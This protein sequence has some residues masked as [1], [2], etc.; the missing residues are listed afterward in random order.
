MVFDAKTLLAAHILISLVCLVV[1]WSTCRVGWRVGTRGPG[2]WFAG[3]GLITAGLGGLGLRGLLPDLVTVGLT[4]TC[5]YAGIG[6]HLLGVQA[7][8]QRPLWLKTTIGLTVLASLGHLALYWA[9]PA[10]GPRVILFALTY[11][12]ANAACAINLYFRSPAPVRPIA[13]QASILYALAALLYLYRLVTGLTLPDIGWMTGGPHEQ[14][15]LMGSMVVFAGMVYT[16]LQLMNNL[17]LADREQALETKALLHQEMHHRTKNNLALAEAL[18]Y[19]EAEQ[20]SD[21]VVKESLASLQAR[22][23]SIAVLH[24]HLARIDQGSAL[25]SLDRYLETMLAAIQPLSPGVDWS[26]EF[27]PVQVPLAMAL[28]VG[29]MV[30]ELVTNSLKYA[31]AGTDR[32]QIQVSLAAVPGNRA[33]VTVSDNGPGA[34]PGQD[35]S[36]GLGTMIITSLAEQIQASL[37]Y[38][39]TPGLTAELE[40]PLDKLPQYVEARNR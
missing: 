39:S 20:F 37:S 6:C 22:L 30:N 15:Y 31:R 34:H 7:F 35:D 16:E 2:L 13:R 38:R 3:F 4:N 28:P 23:H 18:V 25:I 5:L 21:P 12:S 32:L 33:R 10:I 29:L 9:T 1:A 36:Q 11:L 24:D 27:Q 26:L 17:V 19:L 14:L 8:I 40:L